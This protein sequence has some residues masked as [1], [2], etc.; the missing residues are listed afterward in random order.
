M[1]AYTCISTH[2]HTHRHR[3]RHTQRKR[4]TQKHKTQRAY[5]RKHTPTETDANTKHTKH[6]HTHTTRYL[7]RRTCKRRGGMRS[8][9]RDG[10]TGINV[11]TRM[12]I[13]VE[14]V[15]AHADYQRRGD[16]L[17]CVQVAVLG[18]IADRERDQL[19]AGVLGRLEA[20]HDLANRIGGAS[21]LDG[22]REFGPCITFREC[23]RRRRG[24]GRRAGGGGGGGRRLRRHFVLGV[25]SVVGKGR[26][27]GPVCETSLPI[28][29][30][31]PLPRPV[32]REARRAHRDAS[33]PQRERPKFWR[34]NQKSGALAK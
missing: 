14:P 17:M 31:A 8:V 4:Q 7:W 27:R 28:H 9:L 23:S 12:R 30:W 15:G 21:G 16:R 1:Q 26:V 19:Q 20:V 32:E 29:R 34:E 13:A 18:W 33:Q 3:H 24:G 2:T 22:G 6:T 11:A 10:N 5:T 25:L